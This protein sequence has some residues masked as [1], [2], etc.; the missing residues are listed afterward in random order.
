MWVHSF[1]CGSVDNKVESGVGGRLVGLCL[2]VGVLV[3]AGVLG[4][5]HRGN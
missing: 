4:K 5:G 2:R 1:Q 3:A